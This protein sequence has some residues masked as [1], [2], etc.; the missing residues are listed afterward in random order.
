MGQHVVNGSWSV[1]RLLR[2]CRKR[3]T[4][5]P[6]EPISDSAASWEESV[7]DDALGKQLDGEAVNSFAHSPIAPACGDGRGVGRSWSLHMR[8]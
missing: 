2:D 8:A 5:L 6:C 7:T 4:Q 1:A 3:R